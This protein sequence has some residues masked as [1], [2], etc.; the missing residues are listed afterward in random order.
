LWAG[1]PRQE[2]FGQCRPGAGPDDP[3]AK[4]L[5]PSGNQGRRTETQF[6]ETIGGGKLPE[7]LGLK[8]LRM[9]WPVF[10]KMAD[11]DLKALNA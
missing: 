10:S 5:T 3:K 9:P 1:W 8:P 7:Q 6:F 2:F 11:G 4:N